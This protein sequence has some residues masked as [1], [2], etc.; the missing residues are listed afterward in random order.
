MNNFTSIQEEDEFQRSNKQFLT[1]KLEKNIS[2]LDSEPVKQFKKDREG[3]YIE[4][5]NQAQSTQEL[6]NENRYKG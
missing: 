6:N 1:N 5:H 3:K 2:N 4:L